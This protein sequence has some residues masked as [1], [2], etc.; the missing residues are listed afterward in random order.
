MFAATFAN[1]R[2]FNG[3]RSKKLC[4]GFQFL[5]GY[6]AANALL[7]GNGLFTNHERDVCAVIVVCPSSLCGV[8]L[9][10]PVGRWAIARNRHEARWFRW[11]IGRAIG[12]GRC[13]WIAR[14]KRSAG[15]E[16]DLKTVQWTVFPTN[17]PGWMCWVVSLDFS[18]DSIRL[19]L[20][21]SGPIF[22]EN[23]PLDH[24]VNSRHRHSM[25]EK[26]QKMAWET[27]F[28]TIGSRRRITR[29]VG[30][31]KP[32]SMLSSANIFL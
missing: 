32:T 27:N 15:D 30:E 20:M 21:Y 2:F 14:D 19:P 26:D 16:E 7:S 10:V 11:R 8:I 23:D 1:P 18:A 22:G 31:E 12:A 29:L 4:G 5:G 25:F 6:N 3:V 24:F 9:C 17:G 13:G 28:P